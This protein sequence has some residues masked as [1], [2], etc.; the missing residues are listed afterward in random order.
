MKKVVLTPVHEGKLLN[1]FA[2][3]GVEIAPPKIGEPYRVRH[4]S[5]VVGRTGIVTWSS[6]HYHSE[7]TLMRAIFTDGKPYIIKYKELDNEG[8]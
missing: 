1:E 2:V 5:N 7:S 3:E 4:Q 6:Y 8:E